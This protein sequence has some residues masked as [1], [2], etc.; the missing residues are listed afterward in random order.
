MKKLTAV[1]L[2]ALTLLGMVGVAFA[3]PPESKNFVAP[4]SG[5]QEVPA[6]DSQARGNAMLH[7]SKDGTQLSYKLIVANL[8]NILQSHIHC[9]AADV[10]GPVVAFLYPS[11]PPAVLIPGTTNGILAQG[12]I[13]NAN[14]IPRPDSP[15]CPG[16]IA[17]FDELIAK[18]R[19][20]DAYVNVHTTL[21]PGGEIR[22]QIKEGGPSK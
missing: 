20:G 4:L 13:T 3:A 10:N 16:G 17:N 19:A 18:M 1:L 7:L 15:E 21:I 8:D 11:A 5:D 14:I 6:N 2:T 22:G 12:T 9:G